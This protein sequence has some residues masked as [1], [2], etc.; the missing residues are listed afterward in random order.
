MST[1]KPEPISQPKPVG[2]PTPSDSETVVDNE[3]KTS[4][5]QETTTEG[6]IKPSEF[7][8]RRR[9]V[10]ANKPK[11]FDPVAPNK[12]LVEE[13][14]KEEEQESKEESPSFEPKPLSK[15]TFNNI[16]ISDEPEEEEKEPEPVKPKPSAVKKDTPAVD[17]NTKK[18]LKLFAE[19][20]DEAT[21][22][23]NFHDRI[24]SVCDMDEAYEVLGSI[25]LS[26]IYGYIGKPLDKKKEVIE[27]LNKWAVE[28]VPR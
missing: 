11:K 23:K 8:A 22:T 18:V 21:S 7:L 4:S 6:W 19:F 14:Q 28:G 20:I 15:E 17:E 27:L 2:A 3:D 10:E 13:P 24:S 9:K 26:K 1:P 25:G 12:P 16:G 5:S